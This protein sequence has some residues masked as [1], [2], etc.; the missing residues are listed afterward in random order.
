MAQD[1]M[2]IIAE[3]RMAFS[4]AVA[5]PDEGGSRG[6]IHRV[7]SRNFVEALADRLRIVFRDDPNVA[8]LSKHFD[9]H[10]ERFGLNELLFD[11]LGL[12][13]QHNNRRK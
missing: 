4:A 11:I 2:N 7:R 9:G 1:G 3:V 13:Y 5:R 6:S 10:R 8:V 12:S